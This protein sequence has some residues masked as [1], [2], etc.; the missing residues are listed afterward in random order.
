MIMNTSSLFGVYQ[1]AENVDVVVT[2]KSFANLDKTFH[3]KELYR[4][5]ANQRSRFVLVTVF[6]RLD[7]PAFISN[8]AWWTR[9]LFDSCSFFEPG[10]I[11]QRFLLFLTKLYLANRPTAYYT[12]NI[13]LR[14]LLSTP[15]WR[16][17]VYSV[18]GV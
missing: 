3:H 17:G 6:S 15:P 16:P 14:G 5:L 18:P 8:L 7:A 9:R 12:L 4:M 1:A 11:K 13:C 10:F 2:K